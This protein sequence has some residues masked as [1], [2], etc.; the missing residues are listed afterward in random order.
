[1]VVGP[2]PAHYVSMPA[3]SEDALLGTPGLTNTVQAPVRPPD[4]VS[5]RFPSPLL[6]QVT[7]SGALSDDSATNPELYEL[8]SE[9]RMDTIHRQEG[10][11]RAP[12]VRCGS[13]LSVP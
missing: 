7:F 3:E 11:E 5:I 12:E 4:V 13:R 9:V 10:E 8:D 1:M 6:M 2:G